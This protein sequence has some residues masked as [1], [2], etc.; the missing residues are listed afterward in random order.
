MSS[1]LFS[2][3]STLSSI[4]IVA[5]FVCLV[6]ASIRLVGVGQDLKN[7]IGENIVWLTSQAQ[8]EGVR[9]CDTVS[10]YV[11]GDLGI[12]DREVELRLDVFL[13]R[14][15]VVRDGQPRA[16]LTDLG[17]TSKIDEGV[18]SLSALEA[19]IRTLNRSD[20]NADATVRS[21][22]Q[23]LVTVLRD[24]ANKSSLVER[25]RT[26]Q[27]RDA[28]LSALLQVFIY[29]A[30]VIVSCG[31]LTL[32]LLRE[33]R[34]VAL[35]KASLLK[36]REL[37]QLYREF[38]SMV[39]HQFRTPL[40]VIDMTAQRI[41]RR[42]VRLTEKEIFERTATI[43]DAA[44][45]LTMLMESTLN[46]ARFDQGEIAFDPVAC[47]LRGLITEVSARYAKLEPER[48]IEI[49]C[50]TLPSTVL[51]DP[52]LTEQAISNLLSNA[53]KYSSSN[54]SVQVSGWVEHNW[55]VIS[56]RDFGVGIPE[57]DMPRLFDRYFRARTAK[58]IIGTGVGLSFAREIVHMHGGT[59]DVTSRED[60]GTTFTIRLPLACASKRS[61]ETRTATLASAG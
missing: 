21:T 25:D 17:Y 49:S 46:A 53:L 45:R 36:E 8:Y 2:R 29:I 28:H 39:S 27:L 44:T 56:V 35:A 12:D 47:D 13:S 18:A 48:M 7:N 31:I 41:M 3:A 23:P 61:Q 60:S 34:N 42:G 55:I 37:S 10:R 4:A 32:S 43:R 16:Y 30:G 54:T 6:L 58:G 1:R 50:E 14:L 11:G 33:Q 26:M 51:C 20:H 38:V 24:A 22:V 59:I 57:E 15:E 9:L 5:S 52:I 40:T 19:R